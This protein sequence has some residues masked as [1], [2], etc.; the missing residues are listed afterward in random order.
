M[1]LDGIRGKKKKRKK[2]LKKSIG[3][4]LEENEIDIIFFVTMKTTPHF[5]IASRQVF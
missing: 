5:F 1:I 4:H 2:K 3:N